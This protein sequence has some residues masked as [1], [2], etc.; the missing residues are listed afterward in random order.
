MVEKFCLI[1]ANHDRP[2]VLELWCAGIQRL[3]RDIGYDFPVI[4]TSGA[5]DAEVLSRNGITH[6][7]R[8][9]NPVSEKFNTSCYHAKDLDVN[10]VMIVGSDD[11]I[12]TDTLRRLM[13]EMDKGY[14]L[15]GISDIYFYATRHPHRGKMVRLHGTRIMGVCKTIHRRVLDK[16]NWKPWTKKKDWGLDSI[17]SKALVSHTKTWKMLSDTEVFDCKSKVNMNRFNVFYKSRKEVDPQLFYSVLS[18]EEKELLN[19]I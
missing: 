7:I 5:E 6:L 8:P 9:N 10:Y 15:I 12:S 18:K 3:R 19:K 1:T 13:A 4:V 11:I 2:K 16:V 17:A 14:D